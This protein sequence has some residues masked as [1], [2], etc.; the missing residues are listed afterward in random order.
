MTPHHSIDYKI[1]AVKHYL[2][3]TKN[4]TKT[5]FEFNCSRMSLKR[6]VDRYKSEKSVD[7]HNKKAISYKIKKKHVDLAL[8]LLKKNEQITLSEL[9]KLIKKKYK[10]F[11]ISVRHI[12]NVLRDNNITRK[13][14]RHEH[15]PKTRFGKKT[16]KGK[17]LKAFYEKIKKYRLNKI[18]SLDETSIQ[19]AM[20]MEYSRCKKGYRCK[21]KTDDNFVFRKFTLLVAIC[22]SK[23]IGYILYEKSGMTKERLVSFLKKYVF[24]K[25][26]KHLIV[27]DNAGSHKNNYVKE[28]IVKSGNEYLFSIPYTP[29]TNGTIEMFFSQIKHQLKLN[30]KVLKFKELQEEVKIA[31]KKV[32][33]ENYKKYFLYAYDKQKLKLPTRKTTSLKKI[34]TYKV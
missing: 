8:E 17:E 2:N 24:S 28:A 30:K 27:L 15:F 26:K 9:S 6:W 1:N 33:K 5:C 31:I 4:F 11:D 18:I 25:Y 23:C 3:K 13:R 16:N 20:I 32:K 22:N 19:P 10:D 12:G 29:E 34:K 14:T 7:R 21:V